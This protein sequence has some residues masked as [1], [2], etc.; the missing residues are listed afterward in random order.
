MKLLKENQDRKV[1]AKNENVD[2][3]YGKNVVLEAVKHAKRVHKILVEEGNNKLYAKEI[4]N[5][6]K[7]KGILV[8][9][10]PKKWIQRV[11]KDVKHQ[12]VFAYVAPVDYVFIEDIF[13]LAKEKNEEPF[14]LLLDEIFDPHNLGAIFR[15]AEAVGVHGILL[16]KRRSAKLSSTS[17][18]TSAGAVEYVKTALIG[19]ISQTIEKIKK[20]GLWVVGADIKGEQ[21]YFEENL[22]GGILLVIGSEGRGISETVKKHCDYLLQI[23]MLGKINSLNA[24]VAAGIFMYEIFRQRCSRK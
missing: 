6:A 18:K 2:L 11:A 13:A 7:E 9:T 16:P 1:Q 15:T 12:G 5:I 24:S 4:I 3:I 20:M 17:I 14:I 22:T 8:E 23:P 10:A 21:K 19:N